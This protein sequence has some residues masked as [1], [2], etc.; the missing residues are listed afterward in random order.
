MIPGIY[1]VKYWYTVTCKLYISKSQ[2]G[3]IYVSLKFS[4]HLVL[5]KVYMYAF[6][7]KWGGVI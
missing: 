5:R 3:L 7:L 6:H 2:N 4:Y 1:S